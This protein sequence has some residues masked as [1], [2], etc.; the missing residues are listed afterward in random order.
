MYALEI[1]Y[2]H[3]PWTED[4]ETHYNTFKKTYKTSTRTPPPPLKKKLNK[5]SRLSTIRLFLIVRHLGAQL[6]EKP[7]ELPS[8]HGEFS[9]EILE[10]LHKLFTFVLEQ[11]RCVVSDFDVG[12]IR[13]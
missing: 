4:A 11:F 5:S 7:T 1:M 3:I 6:G 9:S 2:T 10:L 8:R 12:I 13:I